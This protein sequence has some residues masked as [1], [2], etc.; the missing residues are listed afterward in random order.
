[1]AE[2]GSRRAGT[3]ALQVRRSPVEGTEGRERTD[4]AVEARIDLAAAAD[5]VAAAPEPVSTRELASSLEER[6]S[7]PSP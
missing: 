1:M 7:V 6:R 4:A 3:E 2:E 5:G